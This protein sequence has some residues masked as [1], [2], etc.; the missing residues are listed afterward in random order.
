MRTNGAR[1]TK[2]THVINSKSSSTGFLLYM[3]K[4]LC[5]V[6]DRFAWWQA[7]QWSQLIKLAVSRGPRVVVLYIMVSIRFLL[8]IFK[9]GCWVFHFVLRVLLP[10]I[11]WR[12][13]GR[14][15]DGQEVCG[16]RASCSLA[17]RGLRAGVETDISLSIHNTGCFKT[18]DGFWN[19]KKPA[20]PVT[21]ASILTVIMYSDAWSV[22][23]KRWSVQHR[24]AV[25]DLFINRE[26]QQH[27]AVSDRSFKDVMLLAS[28][29]CYCGYWNDVKKYQWRTV[30]H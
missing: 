11:G 21:A 13:A 25:V 4:I 5:H 7:G 3:I 12:K 27:R 2:H 6:A 10:L 30:N 14:W 24:I 1:P 19:L 26:L 17:G 9:W 18:P 15:R 22:E 28:I 16:K 8:A 29:F 23:L 20:C